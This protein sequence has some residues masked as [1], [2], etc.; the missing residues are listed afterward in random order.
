MR[1]KKNGKTEKKKKKTFLM[2]PVS[3]DDIEIHIFH[4]DNGYF[5]VALK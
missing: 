3:V 4:S 5:K 2:F 1:R